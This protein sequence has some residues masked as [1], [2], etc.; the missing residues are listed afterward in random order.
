MQNPDEDTNRNRLEILG[1]A[2]AEPEAA[3][4]WLAAWAQRPSEQLAD[5]CAAFLREAAVTYRHAHIPLMACF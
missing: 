2:A 4:A 5:S 1:P 3:L